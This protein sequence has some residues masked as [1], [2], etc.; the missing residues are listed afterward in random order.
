MDP[1]PVFNPLLKQKL[2][3]GKFGAHSY[4]ASPDNKI[5]TKHCENYFYSVTMT[6]W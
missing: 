6:C 2:F 1:I 4:S 5:M 3:G